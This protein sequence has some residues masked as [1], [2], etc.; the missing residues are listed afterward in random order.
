MKDNFLKIALQINHF[1]QTSNL[2]LKAEQSAAVVV[3]LLSTSQHFILTIRQS[4]L[5]CLYLI[6]RHNSRFNNMTENT[7]TPWFILPLCKVL[8]ITIDIESP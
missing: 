8:Y 5:G 7:F 6:L 1:F 2:M 4:K 3:S